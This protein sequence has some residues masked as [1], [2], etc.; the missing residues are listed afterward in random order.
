MGRAVLLTLAPDQ[1]DV[2]PGDEVQLM[3]TATYRE[4]WSLKD[5]LKSNAVKWGHEE[6]SVAVRGPDGK[7]DAWTV[8]GQQ[9]R[10]AIAGPIQDPRA[11]DWDRGIRDY[12]TSYPRTRLEAAAQEAE[13][14]RQG[15]TS[16][17]RSDGDWYLVSPLRVRLKPEAFSQPG[18]YRISVHVHGGAGE[19]PYSWDS[20]EVLVTVH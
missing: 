10:D 2:Q 18:E 12:P 16:G 9:R 14:A 13:L 4:D 17:R 11:L 5:L 8:D 7:I 19:F 3:L 20:N 6:L 15:P 1:V